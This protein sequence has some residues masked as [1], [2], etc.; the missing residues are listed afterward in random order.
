VRVE[1]YA[2][3]IHIRAWQYQ[4]DNESGPWEIVGSRTGVTPRGFVAR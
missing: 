1:L 2:D 4:L 3:V